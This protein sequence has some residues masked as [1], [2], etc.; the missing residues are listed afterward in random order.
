MQY[1]KLHCSN[2]FKFVFMKPMRHYVLISIQSSAETM[3]RY[4]WLT[5]NIKTMLIC[6]LINSHIASDYS[7][8]VSVLPPLLLKVKRDGIYIDDRMVLT[9]RP[10]VFYIHTGI[11]YANNIKNKWYVI[12]GFYCDK[13]FVIYKVIVIYRFP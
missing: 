8:I 11:I 6:N 3:G 2:R 12:S 5:W 7:A 1:F 10:N 4:V 9:I 13:T